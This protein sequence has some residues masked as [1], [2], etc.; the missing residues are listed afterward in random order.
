MKTTGVYL[1]SGLHMIMCM[2]AD[3]SCGSK[4]SFHDHEDNDGPSTPKIP[5]LNPGL[6]PATADSLP[7]SDTHGNSVGT[8]IYSN[9]I[10]MEAESLHEGFA[11]NSR[12]CSGLTSVE[13]SFL[14]SHSNPE[15]L[16]GIGNTSSVGE[17]RYEMPE[18]KFDEN[19]N[20]QGGYDDIERLLG[21]NVLE[22]FSE[23]DIEEGVRLLDSLL[24]ESENTD[25][26][27]GLAAQPSEEPNFP[28]GSPNLLDINNFLYFFDAPESYEAVDLNIQPATAGNSIF[29]EPGRESDTMPSEEL[30]TSQLNTTMGY[31][32]CENNSAA[33]ERSMESVLIFCQGLYAMRRKEDPSDEIPEYNSSIPLAQETLRSL[34]SL[35]GIENM[36]FENRQLVL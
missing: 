26:S 12:D 14:L 20:I 19:G 27:R 7:P 33:L 3:K 1:L 24:G 34:T 21:E 4:R 9:Y 31:N 18:I 6:I 23:Q 15:V 35:P 11:P 32:N 17:N 5:S 8:E 16:N 25:A 36:E 29:M 28:L 10:A 22:D 2:E 30:R 13:N